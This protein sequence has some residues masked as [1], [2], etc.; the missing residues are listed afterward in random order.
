MSNFPLIIYKSVQRTADWMVSIAGFA[1]LLMTVLICTDVFARKFLGFS[2]EAT[3]ELSGY[4]LA[5]GMSWGLAGTLIQRGHIRIDVILQKF[6]LWP[7]AI[8]HILALLVLQISAFAMTY[9]A[10]QLVAE[11]QLLNATDLT[12][13]RTPLIIPQGLWM[14]GLA[15]FLLLICVLMVQ[16]LYHLFKAN[17]QAID[18][19]FKPRTYV[20]EAE[21]TLDALGHK[22]VQL[23]LDDVNQQKGGQ[24]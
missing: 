8:L 15:I 4:L 22:D 5:F 13:L 9:G 16:A 2:T 14:F 10:Y 3:V 1:Y 7:R 20:E 24:S 18:D 11:S 17:P 12:S 21:E 19:M 23:K 6:P